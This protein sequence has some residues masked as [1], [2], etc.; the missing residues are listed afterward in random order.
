ML[1]FAAV[2]GAFFLYLLVL[3][4]AGM[5]GSIFCR[6]FLPYLLGSGVVY[7]LLST[8]FG[9][10]SA[11]LLMMISIIIWCVPALS[12]RYWPYSA[13]ANL[14]WQDG[15]YHAHFALLTFGLFSRGRQAAR[16]AYPFVSSRS[17]WKAG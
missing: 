17:K 7:V 15:H 4:L 2:L 3:P 10:L 6:V 11:G 8:L 13:G 12:V 16:S 9:H 1:E 14:G 5:V